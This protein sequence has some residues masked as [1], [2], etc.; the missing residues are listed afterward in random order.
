VGRMVSAEG[1]VR[2][3]VLPSEQLSS[4]EALERFVTSVREVAP[5]ATGNAV[6][7]YEASRAAVRSFQQALGAAVVVIVVLLLLIWRTIGAASLVLAPLALAGV[8]TGAVAVVFGI[9]INFADI[10]VLPLL[11]GIGVDSG[12]HLVERSRLSHT[13]ASRLLETSTARAVLFSALT[14]IA[15]FGTLGFAGHRGIA[16]MGQLLAV[17]V[18]LAV[19]A[20]LLVLPALIQLDRMRK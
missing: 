12:I 17:G 6:S 9:P 14:T 20:N 16:S 18:A 5:E 4:P 19:L 2:V 15:S 13:A 10:I 1:H 3:R 11:L 7:I 8:L